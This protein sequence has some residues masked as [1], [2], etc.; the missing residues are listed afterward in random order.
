MNFDLEKLLQYLHVKP[1]GD[2][3]FRG[4]NL[5]G[6]R[7]AVFG[8]QVVAQALS[9]AIQTIDRGRRPHSIHCHFLRAGKIGLD[10]DYDIVRVRDGRSFS[11]RQ[12]TALQ[13]GKAIF[14]A[15]VSFQIPEDGLQHQQPAPAMEP[16]DSMISEWEFW[17]RI[18]QERPDLT[19]LRPDNFTALDILS[20]FRPGINFP[21][22]REPRQSFW[23][24]ANGE[25]SEATDHLL[26]VAFQSD[27]LFLNTALHAHSYTLIDPDV[28]AASLDHCL[29]FFGEVD[30]TQWLYY[31]MHSPVSAGARG[32]NHGHFYTESGKL[33]AS[34]AQEGLIRIHHPD[35]TTG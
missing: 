15:T 6:K 19:Y 21:E 23:F 18:Q 7:R 22:P 27:L 13:E 14:L 26:I 5:P 17:Q 30:A 4:T 35:G 24:R 8:G 32:L 31:D 16:R 11:L 29:W 9:A 20:H 1:V 28:Q 33:V 34:T 3:C 25:I 10:I 12:V 2:D